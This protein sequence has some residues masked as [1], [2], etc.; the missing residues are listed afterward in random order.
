MK[1]LLVKICGL[2]SQRDVDMLDEQVVHLCGFIF[3]EKSPR[4]MSIES[5]KT[6]QTYSMKRVGVFVNQDVDQIR[7]V[8][9]KCRLDYAQLHGNQTAKD[10]LTIG[11]SRVIRVMWPMRYHDRSSLEKAIEEYIESSA[12]FLMDATLS[13]GGSGQKIDCDYLHDICIKKHWFLAGGLT[14]EN[15]KKM[16]YK[17]S[18][19]GVDIN[20]GV[21]SIDT[22]GR[23]FKDIEKIQKT[24][25]LLR[26]MQ[27]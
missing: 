1:K 15:L 8:M 16:I 21:E 26:G 3:H 25:R 11:D 10:A 4:N 5:V 19:D 9:D 22:A 13:S 7:R 6:I 18:P 27:R 17:Y 12:Y 20:S 2:Q 23:P 14:Y 24:M